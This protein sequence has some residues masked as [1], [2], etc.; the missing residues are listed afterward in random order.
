VRIPARS[1]SPSSDGIFRPARDAWSR[2][3]PR[4]RPG[5][6]MQK[7]MRMVQ[8]ND[9]ALALCGVGDMSPYRFT[10]LCGCILDTVGCV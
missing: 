6:G 4:D 1:L 10:A 5:S 8:M 7:G 2:P 3:N 9:I